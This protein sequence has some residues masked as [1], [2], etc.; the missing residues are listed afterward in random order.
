MDVEQVRSFNRT[1][2]ERIGALTG[3]VAVVRVGAPT[4]AE[5][6][7]LQHRVEDALS[8]TRAAMAEGIVAGGGEDIFQLMTDVLD[9]AH[10][11][12]ASRP[13]QAMGRAK[14]RTDAL[15]PVRGRAAER[16]RP[17][18]LTCCTVS[19]AAQEGSAPQSLVLWSS[20]EC[21]PPCQGGGRGFKS[22][23]DR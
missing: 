6:K 10:V 22:R 4:N 12:R 11:H 21:S 18:P 23:Q 1:V 9:H 20:L 13:L 7:E 19:L 8:A 5:L 16:V 15:R 17:H 3:K 14:E 2:T